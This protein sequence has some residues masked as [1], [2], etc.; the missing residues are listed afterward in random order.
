MPDG[1]HTKEQLVPPNN[2]ETS[3][4]ARLPVSQRAQRPGR[5]PDDGPDSLYDS[6]AWRESRPWRNTACNW[7]WTMIAQ[8]L[9]RL[10]HPIPPGQ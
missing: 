6:M 7:P 5:C 9:Y 8:M 4:P 3:S 10:D 2:F 1:V